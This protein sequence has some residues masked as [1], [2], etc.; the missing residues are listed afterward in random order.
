MFQIAMPTKRKILLA[1]FGDP[2][3]AFPII[4]LGRELHSRGHDITVETWEVWREQV[5]AEGMGFA[6]APE[7]LTQNSGKRPL[8]PYQ[9]AVRA[10][11][12]T[13]ELVKA[14]KPQIVVSDIITIAPALAA[15]LERVPWATVVPHLYPSNERGSPPFGLGALPPRSSIGRAAWLM[16]A[17]QMQRALARGR[18]DLNGARMRLGLLPQEGLYGGISQELCLVASFPK[19]EYRR[20][21]PSHVKVVG[22]LLWEPQGPEIETTDNG[23]PTVVVAPSTSQDRDKRLLKACLAGLAGLDIDVLVS[24]NHKSVGQNTASAGNIK[25]HPWLPYSK[26]MPHT[27]LV[28]CHGGH[29]TIAHALVHGVPLLIVPGGGDMLEM[30]ARIQWAGA[31]RVLPWRFLGPSSV[32]WAVEELL[33]KPSYKRRAMEIGRPSPTAA[34]TA[35]AATA[36]E[37]HMDK[38][39][40]G[41]GSNPQP[42]G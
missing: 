7:Y 24:T 42:P 2:G 10:T 20:S 15:E 17:G 27:D 40:R 13:R 33:S 8:K 35:T 3:H 11:Y 34:G 36:I 18:D 9:A 28:I 25:V 5:E 6:C 22:P 39:L 37:R 26:L 29:G 31:G 4:A 23:R 30:G 41:W 14:A 38:R 1:G 32:R 21:W 12:T 16:L 19:L